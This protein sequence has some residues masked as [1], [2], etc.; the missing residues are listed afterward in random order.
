M[1][2][3]FFYLQTF[4]GW[5]S[6]YFYFSF[7]LKRIRRVRQQFSTISDESGGSLFHLNDNLSGLRKDNIKIQNF[8]FYIALYRIPFDKKTSIL[9]HNFGKGSN[10]PKPSQ[11]LKG[12]GNAIFLACFWIGSLNPYN[13]LAMNN[14]Q[15]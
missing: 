2:C 12:H 8:F 15:S 1:E 3:S 4:R 13:N 11:A 9:H 10:D 5:W 7:W 6:K 14:I